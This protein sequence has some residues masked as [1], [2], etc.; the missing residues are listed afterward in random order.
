[1]LYTFIEFSIE[2]ELDE[3]ERKKHQPTIRVVLKGLSSGRMER[4]S[5][6]P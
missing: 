6:L 3:L 5:T 1:M 2:S 4:L